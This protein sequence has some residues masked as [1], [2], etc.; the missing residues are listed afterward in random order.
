MKL[1]KSQGWMGLGVCLAVATAGCGGGGSVNDGTVPLQLSPDKAE[2]TSESCRGP[3]RGPD[4]MVTGGVPPFTI[5]NPYP[6]HI[7]LSATSLRES[8]E[9]FRIDLLGGACLSKVP[10]QVTDADANTVSFVVDF[11]EP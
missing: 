5:H 2:I 3:V 8:G 11:L 1:K 6:N 4:V 7:S 9:S 10:V